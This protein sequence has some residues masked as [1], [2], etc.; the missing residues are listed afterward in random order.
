MEF[1]FEHDWAPA[2]GDEEGWTL[3]EGTLISKG[4]WE[5]KDG[6]KIVVGECSA[7]AGTKFTIPRHE[8]RCVRRDWGEYTTGYNN[9]QKFLVGDALYQ[10]E[11][12]E[13]ENAIAGVYPQYYDYYDMTHTYI[14]SA[15]SNNIVNPFIIDDYINKFK[16]WFA[17][18][19]AGPRTW[20]SSGL[21]MG[22]GQQISDAGEVVKVGG[23]VV[24]YAGTRSHDEVWAWS[25]SGFYDGNYGR[26]PYKLMTQ[27]SHRNFYQDP[28]YDEDGARVHEKPLVA[29]DNKD[30]ILADFLYH[31]G[32]A[33]QIANVKSGFSNENCPSCVEKRLIPYS[34][35]RYVHDFINNMNVNV[36]PIEPVYMSVVNRGDFG[37][38]GFSAASMQMFDVSVHFNKE[39]D[40]GGDAGD[41]AVGDAA[42]EL[43]LGEGA[44]N[45]IG[46]PSYTS[47][48]ALSFGQDPIDGKGYSGV[49]PIESTYWDCDGERMGPKHLRYVRHHDLSPN[50]GDWVKTVGKHVGFW[51]PLKE[52]IKWT[53]DPLDE[54]QILACSGL[55]EDIR[56]EHSEKVIR[57][58]A[59]FA[60]DGGYSV[61]I[62]CG[63]GKTI[64][65]E[66]AADC[67]KM[68]EQGVVTLPTLYVLAADDDEAK[69]EAIKECTVWNKKRGIYETNGEGEKTVKS[70]AEENL[71]ALQKNPDISSALRYDHW[72]K[73][74]EGDDNN[75]P[76]AYSIH[77]LALST[78]VLGQNSWNHL[79]GQLY[80]IAQIGEERHSDQC[81]VGITAKHQI[82]NSH[83]DFMNT[84]DIKVGSYFYANIPKPFGITNLALA[85]QGYEITEYGQSEWNLFM[86]EGHPTCYPL[87]AD[88]GEYESLEGQI[89]LFGGIG[90]MSSAKRCWGR[91]FTDMVEYDPAQAVDLMEGP[92]RGC[93]SWTNMGVAQTLGDVEQDDI[94]IP[95]GDEPAA[96]DSATT[97]N[98]PSHAQGGFAAGN[99]WL[100]YNGVVN[101]KLED[102]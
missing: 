8:S 99:R 37:L 4:I 61:K 51:G 95:K 93:P 3:E 65:F 27:P 50:S 31:T 57:S 29:L 77:Q 83:I 68:V 28:F 85:T 47:A 32:W 49:G 48:A 38:S 58:K 19:P 90:A 67:A 81:S 75:D 52:R 12:T 39:D 20:D 23:N 45:W 82:L 56:R 22:A 6:K 13:A 70:C 91:T 11:L 92:F 14:V 76:Y 63:D 34:G 44:K 84:H 66:D 94:A 36:L 43:P 97:D 80:P 55:Q 69:E 59:K 53:K 5:S 64:G 87:N 2:A 102:K 7:G 35:A 17:I 16:K 101:H 15:K 40:H 62:Q 74:E 79:K 24:E 18:D 98:S 78:N 1:E 41:E 54:R 25:M 72:G 100:S 26:S 71:G 60:G 96:G 73:G 42:N 88:L 89:G 21:Y 33:L 30:S 46:I 86:S 9:F 10:L